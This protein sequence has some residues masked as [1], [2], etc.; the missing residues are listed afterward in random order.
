MP[1]TGRRTSKDKQWILTRL[2]VDKRDQHSCQFE[3][4]LTAKEAYQLK[5][6]LSKTLDRCH[7]FSAASNPEWIYNI[8]NIITLKRFIHQ[9]LDSYTSPLDGS[10]IELNEIYW[11]WWRILNK[12][13]KKYSPEINYEHLLKIGMS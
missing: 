3:K 13:T 1:H 5:I 7:I 10:N 12:S 2:E 8:K 4:C 11:W 6:G 9:R